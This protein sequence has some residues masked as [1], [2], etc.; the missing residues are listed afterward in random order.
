[1]TFGI[2]LLPE[3]ERIGTFQIMMIETYEK[4]DS[5]FVK[6]RRVDVWLPPGYGEDNGRSYPVLY[7]HDGQNLFDPA[8]SYAGIPW[9][10]DKTILK[11]MEQDDFQVPIVVGVWNT[12][13]RWEE[14]LP[15]RP[16]NGDFEAVFSE[17]PEKIDGKALSDNYLKFLVE[18]V[19]PFVDKTYRTQTE[20]NQTF[21][22]GSSMGGLISL[23]ALCEYPAVFGGAGCVSTH[24]PAVADVILPYLEAKLPVP[25]SHKLYFDYGTETLDA[26][27]E[28]YQQKIDAFMVQS[29]YTQG[30]DWMTRKFEGAE[31]SEKSW[32]ERVDIP[33]AFLLKA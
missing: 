1:M 21:V 23:Y 10:V 28:P 5:K 18:E 6:P 30:V 13:L 33:L 8:T 24:W 19:K 25:G 17:F 31:H 3:G 14:Y 4:F 2:V 16:F 20:A 15:E 26:L 32:Q 27:Y 12:E 29:G 9:A 11:L 22:M 7:T